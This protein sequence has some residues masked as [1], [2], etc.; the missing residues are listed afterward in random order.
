MKKYRHI[1]AAIDLTEEAPEVLESAQTLAGLYGAS[2]SVLTV[3]R[4]LTYAYTGIETA[5]MGQALMNFEVEA[6]ASAIKRLESL[7]APLGIPADRR[8]VIFGAP[9]PEVR[10]RAKSLGADLIVMGVRYPEEDRAPDRARRAGWKVA[11]GGAE[12]WPWRF[13]RARA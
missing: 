12:R 7:C 2:L 11:K 10:N 13:R 1:L 9:A 8:H 5:T 3:I 6:E 4:P